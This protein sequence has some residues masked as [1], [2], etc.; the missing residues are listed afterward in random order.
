MRVLVTRPAAQASD[1]VQQLRAAGLQAEAL[2]LIDIAPP[3]DTSP[4]VAAWA[5]LA[6]KALVVFVSPNA[7]SRFFAARPEPLLWPPAALAGSPG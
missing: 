1:W 3:A 4:L 2:P 6:Q 5:T 7:V